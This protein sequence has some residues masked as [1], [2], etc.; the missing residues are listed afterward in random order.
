MGG[1]SSTVVEDNKNV[2][3][4]VGFDEGREVGIKG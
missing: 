2:G 4:I 3:V 1:T